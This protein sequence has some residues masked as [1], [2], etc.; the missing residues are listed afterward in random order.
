[1]GRVQRRYELNFTAE[2]VHSLLTQDS[3]YSS[4]IDGYFKEFPMPRVSWLQDI[5]CGRYG[6]A[7]ESLLAEAGSEKAIEAK[8]VSYDYTFPIHF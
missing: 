8:N 1:V 5:S 2:L 3:K 4:L 7:C 6:N